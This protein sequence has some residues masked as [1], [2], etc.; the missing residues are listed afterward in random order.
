MRMRVDGAGSDEVEFRDGV[1]GLAV[2]A[3]GVILSGILGYFA[4]STA[5]SIGSSAGSAAASVASSDRGSATIQPFIDSM[6][7]A[8]AGQQGGNQGAQQPRN[9]EP[10][11]AETRAEIGRIFTSTFAS[12]QLS[13]DDRRYLA[14]VVS[15]RTGLPQPEAEKRVDQARQQAQAALDKARKAAVAAAL[16]TATAMMLGLAAAWFAAQ[17]GGHHRDQNRPA[18]LSAYMHPPASRPTV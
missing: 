16:A 6:M 1:H 9:R 13:P 10:L 12:G 5:A 7:R 15:D 3:V 18:R 8:Q 2:W 14:Q 17:R 4:A 11:P